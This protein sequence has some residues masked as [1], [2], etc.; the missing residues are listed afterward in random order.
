MPYLITGKNPNAGTTYYT[1]MRDG[2]QHAANDLTNNTDPS[3]VHLEFTL[4]STAPNPSNYDDTESAEET[5][6]Q[7]LARHIA[8]EEAAVDNDIW[9]VQDQKAYW[10]YGKHITSKNNNISLSL[11]R[12]NV[13]AFGGQESWE[14]MIM[15]MHELGHTGPGHRDADLDKATGGTWTRFTP[16]GASYGRDSSD[17]PDMTWG[18]KANPPSTF[19][20]NG[21]EN[22][23][24]D[25]DYNNKEGLHPTVYSR[26]S[27]NDMEN[28]ERMHFDWYETKTIRIDDPWQTY[29][30]SSSLDYPIVVAT[31]LSFSGK[32]P[33][34][35]RVRN[36]GVDFEC[37]AE[38]WDYLDGIHKEEITGILA[39][40][41]GY[42]RLDL[43]SGQNRRTKID[44]GG[45]QVDDTWT[46]VSFNENFTPG[47]SVPIVFTQS[48]TF[49]GG[50]AVVTRVRKVNKYGFE[51]RLQEEE[52]KTDGHRSE[53]VGYFA[54]EPGKGYM[55]D[56]KYEAGLLTDT[57]DHNWYKL[58]FERVY[59]NPVFLADMNTFSGPDPC[60]LRHRNFTS[61]SVEI[62]IEEEK[63]VTTE[64]DHR[65]ED[66]AYLVIDTADP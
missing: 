23:T 42:R 64:T 10:G 8:Y 41:S 27:R 46:T 36:V 54:I 66:I 47:D 19:S 52:M 57:V 11:S 34:H 35:T 65:F 24:G 55:E 13:G 38:E 25:I 14:P 43:E 53:F 29:T 45:A 31:P 49:N 40:D 15:A 5:Y 22:H 61:S 6:L 62:K 4:K 7:D 9:V 33:C 44:V 16:M 50:E 51:S 37:R 60:S 1:N 2:V 48:Q 58:S 17:D 39:I 18:S 12:V 32:D 30:I 63:S 59:N 20:C 28:W 56:V 21:D 26:C 3:W